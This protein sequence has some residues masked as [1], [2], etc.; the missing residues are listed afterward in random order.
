[1]ERHLFRHTLWTDT[2]LDSGLT[3]ESPVI[4]CQLADPEYLALKITNAGGNAD[5]KLEVA[6]STDGVTFNAYDSQDPLIASTNT[7]FAGKNPED[8]HI[9]A[10]P[11]APFIKLR[12]TELA[13]LNNNVVNAQLFM[14]E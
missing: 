5:A 1:M 11:G 13:T 9:I 2:D 3:L 14:R 7:E 4:D 8:M 6:F 10:V 12:L